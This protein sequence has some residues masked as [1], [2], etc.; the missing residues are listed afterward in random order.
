MGKT[1]AKAPGSGQA[2]IFGNIHQ[3]GYD[4]PAKPVLL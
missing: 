4:Q 1:C 3:A 2:Y